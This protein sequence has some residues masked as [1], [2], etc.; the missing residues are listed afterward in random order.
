MTTKKLVHITTVPD[1]FIF[2]RGQIAFMKSQGFEIHAIS[3]PGPLLDQFAEQEGVH[4]YPVE[5]PRRITPLQDLRALFQIQNLLQKIKPDLVHAHTPKG[6]LL[7]M[8]AATMAGT[9][10]RIYH[11]RGLPL[12][13]AKDRKKL[14]LTLTEQISCG[15]SH[16]VIAVGPSLR[17]VAIAERLCPPNKITILGA[18]SGNGVDASKR[19]NPTRLGPEVRLKKRTDL[20]IPPDATVIGFVGRIVHDKGVFELIEAWKN[21]RQTHPQAHLLVVG[22]FEPQDPIPAET[23]HILRTDPRIHL[24]GHTSDPAPL[25]MAMDML[26][27][28]TYREG[29]PNVPLEAAAME[30][31]VVATKIPGCTDAVL[32]GQTGTL[33]PS[34]DAP[35]LE[36]AIRLYLDNPDL[37]SQ[38]GLA[39][40]TRVLRDFIQ[41]RIW[42]DLLSIYTGKTPDSPR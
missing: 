42:T 2:L 24:A 38:H 32:D 18:G 6:G 33:V 26:V 30:L 5:M 15:L 28:P 41:S 21:I 35:A 14:I 13:T 23:E 25:Y 4:V 36:R 1:S 19:F 9:P 12:M 7:G 10:Q 20:N 34:Q 31:P 37:R 3:S 22:P 27:L 40:R 8:I 16:Q 11:M 17:E 39:G 29:F